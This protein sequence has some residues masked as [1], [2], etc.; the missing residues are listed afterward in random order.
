MGLY[1]TIRRVVMSTLFASTLVFGGNSA[2]LDINDVDLELF[3]DV[4]LQNFAGYTGG[5]EY[6]M[7]LRYLHTEN[8]LFQVGFTGENSIPSVENLTLGLGL[9]SV[10]GD[11][12]MALPL[13]I[14]GRYT[15][16]LNT[17]TALSL[18]L[19]FAYAPP[20]LSFRDAD[21]YQEFRVG[22][23]IEVIES[24][25]IFAGYRDIRTNYQNFDMTFNDSFYAGLK[26]D[27]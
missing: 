5:T 20:V 11:T 24:I 6:Y 25:H 27:F 10:Y 17:Q 14:Q 19:S 13:L 8:N 9:G 16:P 15:F 18:L 1:D 3:A 26:F 21:S 12:F 7:H 23:D 2:G 22:T 4:D